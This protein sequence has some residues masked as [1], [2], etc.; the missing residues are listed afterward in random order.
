M[1]NLINN[2]KKYFIYI[3][4]ILFFVIAIYIMLM[5]P[6]SALNKMSMKEGFAS[7]PNMTTMDYTNTN[8]LQGLC[9]NKGKIMDSI[10][11]YRNIVSQNLSNPKIFDEKFLQ[12]ALP[13]TKPSISTTNKTLIMSRCYQIESDSKL[14]LSLITKN[15]DIKDKN[16][17][18]IS[19]TEHINIT[20]DNFSKTL[21]A[22]TNKIE[23]FYNT[24]NIAKSKE[25]SFTQKIKG[26]VYVL[27]S[28]IPYYK[29]TT[30]PKKNNVLNVNNNM[31]PQSTDPKEKLLY[32][33]PSYVGNISSFIK[34][35]S[36]RTSSLEIKTP[37]TYNVFIIYDNYTSGPE[38]INN[39]KIVE[40]KQNDTFSTSTTPDVISKNILD[41]KYISGSEQCF[42]S[43]VGTG[44]MDYIGGCTSYNSDIGN[45][46]Q[47]TICQSPI[48]GVQKPYSYVVLYTV[49]RPDKIE[50]VV[51]KPKK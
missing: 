34:Q 14:L 6:N 16:N 32:Y 27:I 4:G 42:I 40:A 20:T 26:C 17:I 31:V 13:E 30:D 8:N 45:P 11:C 1:T 44:G 12:G 47:K 41:T 15:A 5:P 2:I 9:T 21:E 35:V 43:A 37:I 33:S 36:N 22:I 24:L 18:F 23:N 49:N 48:Q 38:S 29:D 51:Y 7:D 46:T 39:N 28:Q 10:T 19:Y 25:T 50:N 3:V